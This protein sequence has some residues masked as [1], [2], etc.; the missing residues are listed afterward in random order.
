MTYITNTAGAP[1]RR[2]TRVVTMLVLLVGF[3]VA[4]A[5]LLL[6]SQPA[7]AG[8]GVPHGTVLARGAFVAPTDVKIKST[9]GGTKR[10]M[11]VTDSADALVQH[12]TIE[13]GAQTG[14]H[15]HPGPVVVIVMTGTLTLYQGDDA[16]CT[17][18][19]YGPGKAF[20]DPG[21]GNVHNARNEGTDAVS[22][23]ATFF[24]V[25]IGSGP[26]I[27]HANPGH[28]TGF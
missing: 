27:G 21:Q 16:S 28:C 18:E 12:I 17:G 7:R 8:H 26:G 6:G 13:P 15:S 24:D 14:W 4:G 10:V 22:L 19:A 11:N 25:P 3:S 2:A 5:A 20:V 9:L 23:Y 1:G